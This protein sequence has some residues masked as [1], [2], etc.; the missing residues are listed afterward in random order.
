MENALENWYKVCWDSAI[1]QEIT[2]KWLKHC[3]GECPCDEVH[4][5]NASGKTISRE[6]ES[7]RLGPIMGG[8]GTCQNR[9][10]CINFGFVSN[11]ESAR[12]KD[13]TLKI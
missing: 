3:A 2:L 13:P 11:G 12:V 10:A 5:K 8:Q 6:N 4:E 1:G 9:A 7:L